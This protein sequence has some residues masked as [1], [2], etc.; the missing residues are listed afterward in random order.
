MSPGVK[1]FYQVLGV[2]KTASAD[3]LKKSYRKLAKKFHPDVTGGDKDKT[4]RFKEITEA[5]QTL[6]DEK[7]RAEYDEKRANPFAGG[8]PGGGPGRPQWTGGF[9]GGS[10]TWSTSGGAPGGAGGA[11]FD[12]SMFEQFFR[13]RG[14]GG[15]RGGADVDGDVGD[16]FADVFGGGRGRGRARGPQPAGD[17]QARLEIDLPTAAIGGKASITIDIPGR[18]RETLTVKIPAGVKNGAVIRLAGKGQK[19][20]GHGGP[21]GDLLLEIETR[22]HPQFT[23]E[24]DDISCEVPVTIE[25]AVLGG[26]VPVPT[27]EGPHLTVTVPPGTSSGAK[28]RLR[29]KGAVKSAKQP[30]DR[31]DLYARIMIQVPRQTDDEAADLL[32]RFAKRAPTKLSR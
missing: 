20:S 25:E 30:D 16:P 15:G 10:Y 9:P 22:A 17:I 14:G 18:G 26:K 29:G 21:D 24:G 2:S 6:G 27:L 11:G 32:R 12:P 28:L 7:Q 4:A 8:A 19:G 5:Y 23:R 31:G 1:D 13:Q 3:E